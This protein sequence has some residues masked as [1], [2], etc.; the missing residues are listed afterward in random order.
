M[1]A[2]P[3][4]EHS[5]RKCRGRAKRA[6]NMNFKVWLSARLAEKAPI[7]FQDMGMRPMRVKMLKEKL[8]PCSAELKATIQTNSR[9]HGQCA[10]A[11]M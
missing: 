3:E 4:H 11:N 5:V 8:V 7:M 1:G 9:P 6:A 2:D 10:H